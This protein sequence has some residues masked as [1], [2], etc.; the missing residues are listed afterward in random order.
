MP[1]VPQAVIPPSRFPRWARN[2][3]TLLVLVS[4]TLGMPWYLINAM[5]RSAWADTQA[6]F[7]REGET[8]E[9]R[10]LLSPPIPEEQNFCASPRLLGLSAPPRQA[11]PHVEE[12]RR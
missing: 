2:S 3:L 7:Q 11:V 6:L 4:L 5:A 10:T 9:F 1:S 12:G 8:M